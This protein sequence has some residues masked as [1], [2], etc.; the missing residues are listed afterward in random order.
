MDRS[1]NTDRR[2]GLFCTLCIF[3]VEDVLLDEISLCPHVSFGAGWVCLI[4]DGVPIYWRVTFNEAVSTDVSDQI[5]ETQSA[6]DTKRR[7]GSVETDTISRAAA[8]IIIAGL[9]SPGMRERALDR[10]ASHLKLPWMQ[11]A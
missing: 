6:F 9:H 1:I 8:A 5:C 10:V 2:E 3:D 7:T 4:P 11:I